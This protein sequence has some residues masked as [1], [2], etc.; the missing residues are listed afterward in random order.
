MNL[1][2]VDAEKCFDQLWLKDCLI[3]LW[4]KGMIE[5]DILMLYKM[6]QKAKVIIDTPAGITDE[7]EIQEIVKQ[8]TVWGPKLCCAQTDDINQ[9]GHQNTSIGT[10]TL[11]S[12]IFVDDMAGMGRQ[13]TRPN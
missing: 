5:R 6:N 13:Q 10:T 8:G 7:F 1:V 12:R 2:F 9:Y 11:N 3:T 4:E